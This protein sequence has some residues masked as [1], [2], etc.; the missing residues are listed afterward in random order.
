MQPVHPPLIY[1]LSPQSI[2]PVHQDPC[3]NS[4][5]KWPRN[6]VRYW[7]PHG[8]AS[9]PHT[10]EMCK[11]MD[12]DEEAMLSK[13]SWRFTSIKFV[14]R[15]LILFMIFLKYILGHVMILF[16]ILQWLLSAIQT[17]RPTSDFLSFHAYPFHNLQSRRPFVCTLNMSSFFCL[18]SWYLLFHLLYIL[19]LKIFAFYRL[20]VI[21]SINQ[22]A[23]LI[24]EATKQLSRSYIILF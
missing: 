6:K 12:D 13:L 2:L 20:V 24:N 18:G 7:R 22:K 17:I 10:L 4:S 1:Q 21:Q 15:A 9:S 14:L 8:R 19:F 3:P 23:F 5:T 16:R 11:I